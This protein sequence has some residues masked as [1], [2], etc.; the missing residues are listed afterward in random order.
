MRGPRRRR[1]CRCR[2]STTTFM[3][4]A[5]RASRCRRRARRS[6][7]DVAADRLAAAPA[8]AAR[9]RRCSMSSRSSWISRR[10]RALAAHHLE[11]VVLGRVVAAG[12]HHAAVGL[13]VVAPRSTACGVGHDA[14][15][16]DVQARPRAARAQR[17]GQARRREAAVAADRDASRR[18]CGA[19][20]CRAR[21][22]VGRRVVGRSRDRRRRGCRTRERFGFMTGASNS[23]PSRRLAST[24]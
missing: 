5:R 16:D 6:G 15:V 24:P 2:A 12:D 10:D 13:E 21:A 4:R 20:T 11:A 18:R 22:R 7:R 14:D 8:P 9:S 3:R 17:R 23:A 1:R 19:G